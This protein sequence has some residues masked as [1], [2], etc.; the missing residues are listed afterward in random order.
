M[1]SALPW[2]GPRRSRFPRLERGRTGYPIVDAGMRQLWATG[3]M[4]NRV[5]M[6]IASFLV[7]HLLIDW[8]RGRSWFWDTLVDADHANNSRT[9]NGSRAAAPTP[10][11]HSDH[12]AHAPVGEV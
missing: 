9:G 10:P 12:G 8:R 6:I 11:V 7:K 2:R 4:H 1:S 5:R 3:W